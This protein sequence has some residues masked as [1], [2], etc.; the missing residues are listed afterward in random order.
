MLGGWKIVSEGGGWQRAKV[1]V[2]VVYIFFR[3]EN[4]VQKVSLEILIDF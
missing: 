3:G 4:K 2:Q 1:K